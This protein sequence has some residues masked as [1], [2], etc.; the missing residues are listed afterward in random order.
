MIFWAHSV[1][2]ANLRPIKYTVVVKALVRE[3]NYPSVSV[4]GCKKKIFV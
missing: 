3:G 4:E 1:S 2:H